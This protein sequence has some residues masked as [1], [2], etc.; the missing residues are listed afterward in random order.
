[1]CVRDARPARQ[2]ALQT[3]RVA[4]LAKLDADDFI[5]VILVDLLAVRGVVIGDDFRFGKQR[6]GDA[7]LLRAAGTR[8]GFEVMAFSTHNVDNT[9][10]SS[11][12]VRE[13]LLASDFA[14]AEKLLGRTY[15]IEGRVAHG[16]KVSCVTRPHLCTMSDPGRR[17]I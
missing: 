10:V 4:T 7:D 11:T 17:V 3:P 13:A 1:M 16:D 14:E 12:R 15:A 9:R 6:K 8:Y 2:D 5:S